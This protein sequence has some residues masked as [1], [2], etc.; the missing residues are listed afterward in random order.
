MNTSPDVHDIYMELCNFLALTNQ[1]GFATKW[2]CVH[3]C[4]W[5]Y[6]SVDF[7]HLEAI[8]TL[9]RNGMIKP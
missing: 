8:A 5:Y 6:G 4:V 3:Y 7:C 1:F 9:E 2:D